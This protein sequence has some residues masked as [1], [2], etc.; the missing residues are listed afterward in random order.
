MTRFQ[1][2]LFAG[3]TSLL[4]CAGALQQAQE[5]KV[6]R[7]ARKSLSLEAGSHG[8][9]DLIEKSGKFLRRTYSIDRAQAGG[10]NGKQRTVELSRPLVNLDETA[11]EEVV[12]QLLRARGWVALPLDAD[13]GVYDWVYLSGPRVQEVRN[14]A[15][16]MTPA[17]VRKRPKLVQ[18]VSVVVP[19]QHA[20]A[21]RVAGNLRV[22]FGGGR[23]CLGVTPTGAQQQSLWI[24]GFLPEVNMVL[25]AVQGL[26]VAGP[27]I[28][29]SVDQ[30]LHA[31]ERRLGRLEQAKR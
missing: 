10:R 19:L 8:V 3:L 30:R 24:T 27:K 29:P 11:C 17:E 21:T 9:Y 14:Y 26:D 7:A 2:A 22:L 16:S 25:D 12:G 15:V 1:P 13:R 4:L 5:P 31:I 23:G 20:S 6:V 28:A 18:F